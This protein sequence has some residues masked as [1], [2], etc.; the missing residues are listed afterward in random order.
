MYCAPLLDYPLYIVVNYSF[1]YPL[2]P[3]LF[4]VV[5][6]VKGIPLNKYIEPGDIK[7]IF[8]TIQ[9]GNT[10]I[11]WLLKNTRNAKLLLM[12]R[13]GVSFSY[14]VDRKRAASSEKYS[15]LFDYSVVAVL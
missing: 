1:S 13:S 8:A 15:N 12:E 6:L 2:P 4:I 7:G 14:A 10:P 9:N 11:H 5:S 3:K